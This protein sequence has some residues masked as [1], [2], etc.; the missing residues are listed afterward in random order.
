[1]GREQRG[2]GAGGSTA[3]AGPGRRGCWPA[4][5]GRG[6]SQSERPARQTKKQALVAEPRG[7]GTGHCQLQGLMERWV[8]GGGA[9]QVLL[10][11]QLL[12]DRVW[13][14]QNVQFLVPQS[15]RGRF[16]SIC[17]T[18]QLWGTVSLTLLGKP[19]IAFLG[20]CVGLRGIFI[21]HQLSSCASVAKGLCSVYLSVSLAV[22]VSV[23]L[24]IQGWPV[25]SAEWYFQ[26][27]GCPSI[28]LAVSMSGSPA[29]RVDIYLC[30]SVSWVFGLCVSLSV[31][32]SARPSVPGLLACSGPCQTP[33]PGLGGR[34]GVRSGATPFPGPAV[35]PLLRG[36]RH[37][38]S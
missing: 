27:L 29:L 10:Q 13:G 23:S 4:G 35:S 7:W 24:V 3:P 21:V 37:C 26:G 16:G 38:R 17:P 9:T 28:R 22:S 2:Q 34:A 1:M 6:L 20:A 25:P 33:P 8:G 31:I 11:A 12:L 19:S 14:L 32:L 36:P 30:L 15:N 5:R 18:V